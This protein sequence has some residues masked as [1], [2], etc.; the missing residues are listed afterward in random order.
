MCACD[1][2]EAADESWGTEPWEGLAEG[3]ER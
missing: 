3:E 1:D 2:I